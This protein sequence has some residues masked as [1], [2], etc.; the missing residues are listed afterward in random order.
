MSC[1]ILLSKHKAKL[2]KQQI[3]VKLM[4]AGKNVARLITQKGILHLL[5][6]SRKRGW[7]KQLANLH[8]R[9]RRWFW[10]HLQNTKLEEVNRLDGRAAIQRDLNR[11]WGNWANKNIMSLRE[12]PNPALWEGTTTC[13][14]NRLESSLAEQNLGVLGG[15]LTMGQQ[16]ILAARAPRLC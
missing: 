8:Y 13:W 10:A 9:P 6:S 12:M 2:K 5:C 3:P 14:L 7:P 15:K 16:W 11:S 4:K 1:W